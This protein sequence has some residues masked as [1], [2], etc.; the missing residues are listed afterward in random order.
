MPRL[1]QSLCLSLLT[2]ALMLT[3]SQVNA[4]EP[5]TGEKPDFPSLKKEMSARLKKEL[6]CVEASKDEQALR[7]CRHRPGGRGPHEGHPDR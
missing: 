7:A 3:T 2:A 1:T 6:A 5:G 4:A